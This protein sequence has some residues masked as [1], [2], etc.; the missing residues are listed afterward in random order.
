MKRGIALIL[1]L[2]LLTLGIGCAAPVQQQQVPLSQ[3]I[4]AELVNCAPSFFG[5]ESICLVSGFKVSNTSSQGVWVSMSYNL[6]CNGDLVSGSV[7]P[8]FYIPAKQNVSVQ[9]SIALG[10][11]PYFLKFWLSCSNDVPTALK[12]VAPLWKAMGGKQPANMPQEIWDSTTAQKP[13]YKADVTLQ[14]SD[15][16]QSDVLNQTLEW[17]E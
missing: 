1:A 3:S 11:T 12:Q 2:V 5:A 15:G 6:F 10:Y 4:K 14:V 16:M 17:S 9:D 8:R 7:M 13:L